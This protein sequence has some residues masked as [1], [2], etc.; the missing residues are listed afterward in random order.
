MTDRSEQLAAR[1]EEAAD[2][3]LGSAAI[4]QKAAKKVVDALPTPDPRD[5]VNFQRLVQAGSEQSW[6]ARLSPRRNRWPDLADIDVRIADLDRRQQQLHDTLIDLQRR[7]TVADDDYAGRMAAWMAAGQVDA[8]PQSEVTSLDDA[9][10]EARAERQAIDQLRADV[11]TERIDL[12][13]KHR[14]RLVAD[15]EQETQR[16]HYRYLDAI[17]EAERARDELIGLRETTV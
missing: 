3:S 14:K 7:R 4:A 9:I 2:I 12:V 16:A 17:A 5:D 6:L 1:A 10:A 8:K 11:L 15:A 13:A